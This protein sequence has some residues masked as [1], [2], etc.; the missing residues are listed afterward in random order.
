MET[1]RL[2][3]QGHWNYYGLIGNS[4]S[5]HQYWQQTTRLV[6]KWLNRR[7]Q[8]QSYRWRSF[9]RMLD[10]FQIHH[11]RLRTGASEAMR[12]LSRWTDEHKERLA[13]VNLFGAAH[14]AAGAR[15]S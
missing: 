10:R 15:A 12:E 5:L 2:K 13:R 1:L 8:R 14:V 7:G 3:L 6:F 4:K 9:G 11:P